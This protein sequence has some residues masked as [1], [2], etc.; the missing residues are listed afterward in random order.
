MQ[1]FKC[2]NCPYAKRQQNVAQCQQ[3]VQNPLV[4][5]QLVDWQSQ[6]PGDF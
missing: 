2:E 6:E 5:A 1:N 3:D 4:A